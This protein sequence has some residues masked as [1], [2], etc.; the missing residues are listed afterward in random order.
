MN[1]VIFIKYII[2][3]IVDR[4]IDNRVFHNNILTVII[5]RVYVY[6]GLGIG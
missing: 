1:V 3:Y 6:L 4:L 2:H 5:C